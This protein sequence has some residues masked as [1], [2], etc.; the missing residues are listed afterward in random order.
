MIL[1]LFHTF[2]IK[3]EEKLDEMITNNKKR[4][5]RERLQLG[6][7]NGLKSHS[8]GVATDEIHPKPPRSLKVLLY[9]LLNV[10]NRAY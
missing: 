6:V 1:M 8:L 2:H 10:A 9:L 7:P 4:A 5:A 3:T